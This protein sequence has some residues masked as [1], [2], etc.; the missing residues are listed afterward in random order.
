MD[1]L[2]LLA[3]LMVGIGI[4]LLIAGLAIS[5]AGFGG[6]SGGGG[7]IIFIGPI[8]VFI[9]GNVSNDSVIIFSVLMLL[10]TLGGII[11]ARRKW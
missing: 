5:I 11:I 4:I 7:I 1:S 10:L 2:D 6:G 3:Y 9:G 8:P